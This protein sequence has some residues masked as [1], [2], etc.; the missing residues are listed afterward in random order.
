MGNLSKRKHHK[1]NMKMR[2]VEE[3][4]EERRRSTTLRTKLVVNVAKTRGVCHFA[5]TVRC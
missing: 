1:K 3:E 5:P 2:S 4:K